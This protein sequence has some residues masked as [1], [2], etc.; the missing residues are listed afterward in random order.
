MQ[1]IRL[2]LVDD[3]TSF[4]NPVAKRLKKRG[5]FPELA[6]GGEQC[7][8]ILESQA[9]DVVV[10]DIK[11]PGMDGIR[12]LKAIRE[13]YP[14]IEVMLLT[15]QASIQDGVEGIKA[16]A[17]DYLTKPIE[18]EQLL[19]KIHLAYE[20]IVDRKEKRKEAEFRV[21]Y[22]EEVWTQIVQSEKLASLGRLAAGVAHEINNPLTGILLYGNMMLEKLEDNNPLKQHLKYVLEDANRC[23]EIVKNL[24]AY[25]RQNSPSKEQFELNSLV[26][27]SLSLIED[28][29]IF[30]NFSLVKEL[31][32]YSIQI[33]ADKNQLT[34]VIINL[35]MNAVDAMDDRG[36]L[37]IRTYRDEKAGM[38]CLEVQDTGTGIPQEVISKIF[39]PFFTTKMPGKGT[40]LG[41]S[42]IYG[43]VKENN[44][45][46]SVKETSHEGTT[47]ILE[48]PI[49]DSKP[50]SIG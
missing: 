25:S 23:K 42:T 31:A 7:L 49:K 17:F 9:I 36:K 39:D 4:L 47:F 46:I 16:G 28:H 43:I 21:R 30:K 32:D 18:I 50:D 13:K 34:Q 35:V 24:L 33:Y 37:T 10:T 44:G 19:E 8:S 41:L 48:L 38:A 3:E 11:M 29:K 40:G 5:I 12:L 26:Q 15:G 14:D 27:S 1:N 6:S 45:R 2:L 22:L 20:K